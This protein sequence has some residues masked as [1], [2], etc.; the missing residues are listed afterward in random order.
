MD[1]GRAGRNFGELYII[2]R[3]KV[4]TRKETAS[5]L[6]NRKRFTSGLDLVYSI[7][8]PYCIQSEMMRKLWGSVETE[9]PNSGKMLG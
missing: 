8:L 4:G 2:E 6:T 3:C 5:G 9:T 1:V 7:T